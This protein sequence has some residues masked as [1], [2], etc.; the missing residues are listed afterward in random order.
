MP[1]YKRGAGVLLAILLLWSAPHAAGSSVAEANYLATIIPGPEQTGNIIVHDLQSGCMDRTGP[2]AQST[3]GSIAIEN[4]YDKTYIM[5][6]IRF[7]VEEAGEAAGDIFFTLNRMASHCSLPVSGPDPALSLASYSRADG[8]N[9]SLVRRMVAGME[10]LPPRSVKYY[11]YLELLWLDELPEGLAL[12]MFITLR[13]V[14]VEGVVYLDADG[15]GRQSPGERGIPYAKVVLYDGEG[16]AI[17]LCNSDYRG[18]YQF[19][20]PVPGSYC[21]EAALPAGYSFSG[22]DTDSL[23]L[24]RSG[25][26]DVQIAQC[27]R[28]DMAVGYA[29]LERSGRGFARLKRTT[30]QQYGSSGEAV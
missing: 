11:N 8:G 22:N 21:I 6:D 4:L 18:Y 2:D 3:T 17:G 12:H 25:P 28:H 9:R 29:G 7:E 16:E 23:H 24:Y 15:D 1:S 14:G 5:T 20:S 19:P 13:S 30:N 27:L 26:L 10:M